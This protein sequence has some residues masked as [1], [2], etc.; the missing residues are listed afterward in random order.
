MTMNPEETI[1]GT[2]FNIQRF[3][4]QDGPGIRTTVF[5]KGCPLSCLWCSN[6]ESQNP[7]PEVA[8][9]DLLC[10]G[11]GNCVKVCTQGAIRLIA[12]DESSRVKIDREKCITCGKCVAECTAEALKIYGQRMSVEDVF[13]E[14]RRDIAFYENSGGGV[15]ASGGEPLNQADFVRELFRRCRKIGIHTAM[16]T[17]GYGSQADLEKVLSE[18]DLV[19]Y[20]LK[21]MNSREHSKY[22]KKFNKRILN[23]ARLIGKTGVPLIIRVPLI[24]GIN[25]SE[26]NMDEMA[27]FVYEL[28]HERPVDLL[29]YHRFGES[30]YKMLDRPYELMDAKPPE[31]ELL[32]R[33][34]AIFK[35]YNLVCEIQE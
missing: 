34:V 27:Q 3:S 23:N 22:T 6:P 13:E 18:T 28:D 30:K 20:D 1:T 14:V 17:C 32:E 31:G 8:H 26:T 21:L 10:V 24:P 35:R 11:C 15:T 12:N 2:I 5:L 33:A 29:P 7:L 9:R 16:E 4:I 25:D 19:L